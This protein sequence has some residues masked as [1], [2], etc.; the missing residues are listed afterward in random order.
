MAV[1]PDDPT[2]LAATDPNER[3]SGTLLI[4]SRLDDIRHEQDHLRD[5]FSG[6]RQDFSA[7]RQDFSALRQ[8]VKQDLASFRLEVKQD[9][10]A[11]RQEFSHA[12]SAL[13]YWSW[14]S[15]VA[16]LVGVIA[17]ILRTP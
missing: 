16:V 17:V 12:I 1:N 5:D 4:L 2:T 3:V 11:Q 8:E 14:G 7:L 9:L 13:R 10:M 6:L 15:I